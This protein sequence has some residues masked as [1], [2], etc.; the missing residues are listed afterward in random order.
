M[1]CGA[2]NISRM[3]NNIFF[4]LGNIILNNFSIFV[5]KN[6]L[7][8]IFYFYIYFIINMNLL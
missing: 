5:D 1:I 7:I 6:Y 8:K 3:L 2:M 4:K